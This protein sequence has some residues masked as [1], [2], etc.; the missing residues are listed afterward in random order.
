MMSAAGARDESFRR[1]TRRPEQ[2]VATLLNDQENPIFLWV[3][4]LLTREFFVGCMNN[5]P[6]YQIAQ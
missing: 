3:Q 4:A 5:L 2:H 6:P 1:L